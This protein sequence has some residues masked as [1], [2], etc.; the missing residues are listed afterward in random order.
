MSIITTQFT[1]QQLR[2][3]AAYEQMRQEGHHNM[4]SPRVAQILGITR[5]EQLFIMRNY[6]ALKATEDEQ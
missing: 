3:F 2:D 1:P 5:K 4:A 6:V